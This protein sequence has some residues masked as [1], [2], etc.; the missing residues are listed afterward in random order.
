M[1]GL[2]SD[3]NPSP[4]QDSLTPYQSM[5]LEYHESPQTCFSVLFAIQ[6][7]WLV[8]VLSRFNDGYMERG[9]LPEGK[10]YSPST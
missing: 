5:V 4:K 8:Q 2:S 6:S 10:C 9:D 7:A 3:R 1:A